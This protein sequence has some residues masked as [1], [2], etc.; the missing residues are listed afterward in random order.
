M[1]ENNAIKYVRNGEK[2]SSPHTPEHTKQLLH[3][4]GDPTRKMKV[5]K[6]YGEVG[7]S[8]LCAR[9]CRMLTDARY[10]VGLISLTHAESASKDSIL[11]NGS[12]ISGERFTQ[13]VNRMAEALQTLPASDITPTSEEL[14]L[15]SGIL[16][17]EALGCNILILEIASIPHSAVL[18][19]NT[20]LLNVIT[21]IHTPPVANTVCSLFD[22]TSEETVS[23][24]Q[25]PEVVR[26]LTERCAQVNCRLT[27]PIKSNFYHMEHT[28]AK[29]RFF[30]DK[31]EYVL[32]SGALYEIDT[33]L[34]LIEGYRALTRRG[35]RLLPTELA[36]A[37]YANADKGHFSIF[38]VTPTILLDCAT[39]PAS[40]SSLFET[41][42]LHEDVLGN[43]FDA[44]TAPAY[45]ETVTEAFLKENTPRLCSLLTID[46]KNPYKAVKLALRN[47]VNDRPIIV[48]GDSIFLAYI[49]RTLK[50]FL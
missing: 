41:L 18:A 46:E 11:M 3:A 47:R 33:A 27:F 43:E 29:I 17:L 22:K 38:S 49:D 19:L 16:C 35:L 37:L 10:S 40:L 44:W 9:L 15:V 50:G 48:L 7:K 42:R 28:L 14:L 8:V 25:S 12:P 36:N 26:I 24:L 6:V 39:T 21:K 23:V 32:S 31:Q 13:S 1:N 4:L 30:Y 45:A 5:I 2:T 34:G 20:P